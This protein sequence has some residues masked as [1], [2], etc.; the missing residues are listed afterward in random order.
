MCGGT[1]EVIIQHILGEAEMH[2]NC[3]LYAQVTINPG[4]T[5]GYHEHHG[6]RDSLHYLVKVNMMIMEL[7]EW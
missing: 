7:P 4:S 1:G 5:L 2:N 6:E 3:K